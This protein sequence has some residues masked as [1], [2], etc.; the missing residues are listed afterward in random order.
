VR[1]GRYSSVVFFRHIFTKKLLQLLVGHALRLFV[2]IATVQ[3]FD[4]IEHYTLQLYE[5]AKR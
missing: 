2:G 5:R 1:L 4:D 3:K